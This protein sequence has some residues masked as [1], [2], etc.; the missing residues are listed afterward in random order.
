MYI[1]KIIDGSFQLI[2]EYD[3]IFLK[4]NNIEFSFINEGYL[5]FW[6]N[7]GYIYNINE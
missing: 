4:E 2:K 6:R 7:N 3:E 1:A 5:L